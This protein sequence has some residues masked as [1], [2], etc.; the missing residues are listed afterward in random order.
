M[1]VI[2]SSEI[3]ADPAAAVGTAVPPELP[4]MPEEIYGD[5]GRSGNGLTLAVHDHNQFWFVLPDGVFLP[6][7]E[8]EKH[9][10]GMRSQTSRRAVMIA[11]TVFLDQPLL[12]AN[13]GSYTKRVL[14]EFQP[15]LLVGRSKEG[16]GTT[17]VESRLSLEAAP[18]TAAPV[19][20]DMGPLLADLEQTAQSLELTE[21]LL[22]DPDQL[23]T[24]DDARRHELQGAIARTKD[25]VLV[26]LEG[27]GRVLA[28]RDSQPREAWMAEISAAV[29]GT[30]TAIVA[31]ESFAEHI[32]EDKMREMD[33]LRQSI[34]RYFGTVDLTDETCEKFSRGIN[35][36]ILEG[37]KVG[38]D[39]KKDGLET[40]IERTYEHIIST[41]H[42]ALPRGTSI[43]LLP[44]P[45]VGSANGFS[46]RF[47]FNM[48]HLVLAI[49][50]GG[51]SIRLD[52]EGFPRF[53]ADFRGWDET[54]PPQVHI[55][56]RRRYEAVHRRRQTPGLPP[57]GASVP[58]Q[59]VQEERGEAA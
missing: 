12:I 36:M 47:V 24:R 8:A 55:T 35:K 21:A 38:L 2:Q 4:M 25:Q 14:L 1:S 22:A 31:F 58:E 20:P 34:E 53:H 6:E 30:I 49:Q 52:T 23:T 7:G 54:H 5:A 11:R 13:G 18:A 56:E 32:R 37:H 3:V 50:N 33:A 42:Q 29:T 39:R 16:K 15:C 48:V 57:P 9:I 46:V 10:S 28:A 51:L 26:G 19:I 41:L 59:A 27:L 45:T 43:S 44:R 40:E 17:R